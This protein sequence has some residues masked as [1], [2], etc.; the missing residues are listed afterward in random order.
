MKENGEKVYKTETASNNIR[1]H[2]HLV[3]FSMGILL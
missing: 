1:T 2:N 3:F